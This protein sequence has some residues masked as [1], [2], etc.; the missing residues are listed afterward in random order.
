MLIAT[1]AGPLL[2]SRLKSIRCTGASAGSE[3]AWA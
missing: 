3:S 2:P 1:L